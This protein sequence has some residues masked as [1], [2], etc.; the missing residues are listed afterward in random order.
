MTDL[1]ADDLGISFGSFNEEDTVA[2]KGDSHR[3]V[4]DPQGRGGNSAAPAAVAAPASGASSSATTHTATSVAS[5]GVVP[6]SAAAAPV[7]APAADTAAPPPTRLPTAS[8][9]ADGR[10]SGPKIPLRSQPQQQ[11]QQHQQQRQPAKPA[12]YLPRPA[13]VM[14]WASVAAT[15]P[16]PPQKAAPSATPPSQGSSTAERLETPGTRP[17]AQASQPH[18]N[19]GDGTERVSAAATEGGMAGEVASRIRESGSGADAGAAIAGSGLTAT[20]QGAVGSSGSNGVLEA[21]SGGSGVVGGAADERGVGIAAAAGGGERTA[22]TSGQPV[23]GREGSLNTATP[24]SDG[25]AEPSTTATVSTA[26][27]GNVVEQAEASDAAVAAEEEKA[28][29]AEAAAAARA[30]AEVEAEAA[31]EAKAEAEAKAA[32]EATELAERMWK[33]LLQMLGR[34]DGLSMAAQGGL[35]GS[36]RLPAGGLV[37]RGLVNT[38]NSCFRNSVL[39]ALLACEPFVEVLFRV[40]PGLQNSVPA[41]EALPT[42]AQM[43]RFA[44]AFEPPKPGVPAPL[45]GGGGGGG[46]SEGGAWSMAKGRNR[47]SGGGGGGGG[48]RYHRATT[49]TVEPVYPDEA[50]SRAFGAFRAANMGE[51][52]DAQ[53]FLAFFLDQLHEEIVDAKKKHV[54]TWQPEGLGGEGSGGGGGG[55]PEE[56][57]EEDAWL[58]VGKGGTKAV[59]NAPDPK[60][61]ISNSSVVTGLFYGMF[62]SEVKKHGA[63]PSVTLEA[64]HCLQLDLDPPPSS[65]ASQNNNPSN[66]YNGSTWGAGA[67]HGD[68]YSSNGGGRGGSGGSAWG[69]AGGRGQQHK[70]RGEGYNSGGG[71]GAWG[72]AW[73]GGGAGSVPS[74]GGPGATVLESALAALFGGEAV[75]GVKGKQDMEVKASRTLTLEQAPKVL[76]LHLK[77]FSFHPEL[78]PRKL[79]RRVRYPLEL[80]IPNRIMSPALK[81]EAK[82]KGPLKYRLFTVVLH[83]GRSLHGGHYTALVRGPLGEWKHYDDHNVSPETEGHALNPMSGHPYLLLYTRM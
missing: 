65:A 11:Q 6:A 12:P 29:A 25:D 52:E 36:G 35:V 76:T 80:E 70:P 83:H 45:G 57:G 72:G 75:S 82:I 68:F 48:G 20:E 1:N 69:T 56:E 79:A 19:G 4:N 17:T 23:E 43:T 74:P 21:V 49:A 58:E 3:N 40:A 55:G 78:G 51:Q 71:G 64:F 2:S 63:K 34:E 38:G 77:Q 13:P 33:S 28:A 67:G 41:Q 27:S 18:G 31:A 30:K 50:M 14:S 22:A 10:G 62:R 54:E 81:S 46:S 59:V 16:R 8:T 37:H 66:G 42:W 60:R 26:S 61:K 32:A 44:A 53:E 47:G 5:T 39:Q 7:R 9:T 73:S 24:V 15:R